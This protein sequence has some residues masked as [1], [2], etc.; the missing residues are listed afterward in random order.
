MDV[1]AVTRH[2]AR[3]GVPVPRV[4]PNRDGQ[5]WSDCDGVWRVLTWMPGVG[6]ERA[7][8]PA[9][10]YHAAAAAGQFHAAA[11]DLH[12]TFR[13][14]RAGVHDTPKHIRRLSECVDSVGQHT[15]FSR[16]M[17]L[18]EEILKFAANLEP[19]PAT[20]SRIT[21]GDLKISNFLFSADH[22][23]VTAILD[24]DTVA[25]GPIPIEMGDALRSW[26]NPAGEDTESGRCDVVMFEAAC[27][28]YAT[29]TRG[30]L[31]A[32]ERQSF[33]AA[34]MQ[35]AVELACRFCTDA[36]ENKYFGWN[37][38]KFASRRQHNR[39]RAQGQL[40]LAISIANQ[41]GELEA[42]CEAAFLSATRA[43][44]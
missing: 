7:D 19:L 37:P 11:A 35:I 17:P 40:A 14:S 16:L 39:V 12:H 3:H 22:S 23:A 30:W 31:T 6:L 34:T 20:P 36:F 44:G 28:G 42:G 29:T 2:V 25:P 13:F 15:E 43:K 4:V 8:S 5:L 10:A 41:R 33:V 9:V 27:A 38:H 21:H 26:S 18:A 1:D 24:L 32:P